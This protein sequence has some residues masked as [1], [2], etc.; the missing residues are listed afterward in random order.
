MGMDRNG[1][2]RKRY[3]DEGDE[4]EEEAAGGESAGPTPGGT[5]APA[6]NG[7]IVPGSTPKVNA[8]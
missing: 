4:Y 3:Y 1:D 8:N 7:V 2:D 6:K 5:I